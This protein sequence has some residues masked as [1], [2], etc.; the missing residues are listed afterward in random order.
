MWIENQNNLLGHIYKLLWKWN[1]EM[2][3]IKNCL[4]KWVHN[5][6]E[7]ITVE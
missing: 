2:E 1:M 6:K 3:Q 4:M 7:V 5:F